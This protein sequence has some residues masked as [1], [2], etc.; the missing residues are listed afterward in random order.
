MVTVR[1]Q[2]GITTGALAVALAIG[3]RGENLDRPLDDT[4]DLGQRLL[5]PVLDLC[6][7]LGGLHPVIP[8]PFKPLGE[9]MLNHAADKRLDTHGFMFHP[10]GAVSG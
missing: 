5:N 2:Q 9:D 1:T 6:K 8:H 4:L 7:G 10:V 3:L